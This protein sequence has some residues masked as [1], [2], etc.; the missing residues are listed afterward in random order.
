MVWK[1]QDWTCLLSGNE[2]S[3]RLH[4]FPVFTASS[5]LRVC[6][7]VMKRPSGQTA[8]PQPQ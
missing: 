1:T 6:I 5:C 2:E 8:G 4:R 7:A 3:G